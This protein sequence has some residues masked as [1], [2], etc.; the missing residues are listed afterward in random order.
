MVPTAD[1]DGR[2]PR[3][4]FSPSRKPC[5]RVNVAMSVREK[6]KSAWVN[7]ASLTG[8]SGS[9]STPKASIYRG[10]LEGGT[11]VCSEF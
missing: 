2:T 4:G 10:D 1:R 6:T 5:P 3:V 7:S 11:S 9:T 8:F